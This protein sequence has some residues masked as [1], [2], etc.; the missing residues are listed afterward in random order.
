MTSRAKVITVTIVRSVN[1]YHHILNQRTLVKER[2]IFQIK[3]R[4]GRERLNQLVANSLK[5]LVAPSR[6]GYRWGK[7]HIA[8]GWPKDV[9]DNIEEGK[10]G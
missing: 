3:D 9:E 1:L 7:V 6:E 8:S 5:P 10:A 4:E 2:N